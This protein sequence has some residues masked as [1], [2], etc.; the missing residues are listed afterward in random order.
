MTRSIL[1]Q[2]QWVLE[3]VQKHP[4]PQV[5]DPRNLA[6]HRSTIF[7][8]TTNHYS[9]RLTKIGFEY[10]SQFLSITKYEF[11]IKE[12]LMPWHLVALERHIQY[13]YYIKTLKEIIVFDEVTAMMLGLHGNDLDRYLKNL[14]EHS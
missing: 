5:K 7:W 4:L 1:N 10:L 14:E 9:M 11:K 12:K 13:P 3:F 8:N 6:I 2:E